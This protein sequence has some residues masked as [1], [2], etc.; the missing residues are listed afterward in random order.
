MSPSFLFILAGSTGTSVPHSPLLASGY[1]SHLLSSALPPPVCPRPL[2]DLE[3]KA[4]CAVILMQSLGI[5]FKQVTLGWEFGHL[6]T[7]V[8]HW[9]E[10]TEMTRLFAP[11]HSRT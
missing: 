8:D 9:L 1:C 5:Y 3:A 11:C 7:G 6:E 4:I 10:E 2:A